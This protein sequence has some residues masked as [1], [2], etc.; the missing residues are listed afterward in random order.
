MVVSALSLHRHSPELALHACDAI[1]V[2]SSINL[3]KPHPVAQRNE[4]QF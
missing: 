2:L 1:R 3:G 4:E